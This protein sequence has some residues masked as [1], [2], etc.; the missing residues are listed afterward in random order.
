MD[1]LPK[2]FLKTQQLMKIIIYSTD[3]I[4]FSCHNKDECFHGRF[5]KKH[6]DIKCMNNLFW[7]RVVYVISIILQ[8]HNKMY[9][10][11]F[12]M[13]WLPRTN[14][15]IRTLYLYFYKT[16]LFSS[17]TRFTVQLSFKQSVSS[18]VRMYYTTVKT[19]LYRGDKFRYDGGNPNTQ[20]E[21]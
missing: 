20:R 19:R 8:T 21:Q 11:V 9:L 14:H 16:N 7:T 2:E 10:Y 5:T 3:H 4:L 1:T 6:V 12:K 15:S 18:G 13:N 17:H